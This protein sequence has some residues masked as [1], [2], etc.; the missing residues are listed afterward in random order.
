MPNFPHIGVVPSPHPNA[1]E[2]LATRF[3]SGEA[4]EAELEQLQTLLRDPA[5]RDWFAALRSRWEAA[6]PPPAGTFDVR[7]ALRRLD[8]GLRTPEE[9]PPRAEPRP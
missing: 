4:T 9:P 7:A 5:R 1:L 2:L 6:C 3:L 8:A